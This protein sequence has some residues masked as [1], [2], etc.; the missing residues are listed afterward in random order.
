MKLKDYLKKLREESGLTQREF[1]KPLRVTQPY[2]SNLERGDAI[3]GYDLIDRLGKHY[4]ADVQ[5]LREAIAGVKAGRVYEKGGVTAPK[6]AN[7]SKAKYGI[8]QLDRFW[9][10][11]GRMF[12]ALEPAGDREAYR[13]F[14]IAGIREKIPDI[15]GLWK[16]YKIYRDELDREIGK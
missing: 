4:G 2:W 3:P 1:V 9:M 13:S 11:F 16:R 15:D 14:F 12:E 7:E 6:T 5:Y 10:E 8:T